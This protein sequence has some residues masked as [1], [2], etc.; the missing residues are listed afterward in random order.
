LRA[1]YFYE[2]EVSI[3]NLAI[4]QFS[5]D[6]RNLNLAAG[7]TTGNGLS[8]SAWVRNATDYVSLIGAFP[9]VAQAGS[10]SGYRTPLRIYGVTLSKDF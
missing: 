7:L 2:D 4:S 3:G 1:D 10:F 8:I 5:R 9:S 6:T